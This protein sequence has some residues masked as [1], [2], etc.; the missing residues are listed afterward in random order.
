[1]MDARGSSLLHGFTLGLSF[2]TSSAEH[3]V[4]SATL[5]QLLA[6]A[7]W[8][9]QLVASLSVRMSAC[10]GA[11][12]GVMVIGAGETPELDAG[13]SRRRP[14]ASPFAALDL[15]LPAAPS[16]DAFARLALLRPL[17]RDTFTIGRLDGSTD[18]V[19][20]ARRWALSAALGV[21]YEL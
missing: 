20:R 11:E 17:I 2:Y 8:C 4:A 10:I 7:G 12:A 3:S 13:P 15:R 16:W 6:S 19:F 14:Q 18:N 21:S 5:T 1:M 9:P